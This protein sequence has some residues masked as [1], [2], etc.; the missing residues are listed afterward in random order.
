MKSEPLHS[1]AESQR[2]TGS[3]T[4]YLAVD[5]RPM[6]AGFIGTT[7]STLNG[8]DPDNKNTQLPTD[9]H[10]EDTGRT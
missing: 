7:L 9:H 3:N 8:D 10:T 2:L 1:T 6:T 4:P 5:H